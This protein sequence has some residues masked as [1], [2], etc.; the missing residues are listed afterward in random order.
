MKKPVAATGH[1]AR[2]NGKLPK[3]DASL[4][5]NEYLYGI[6]GTPAG[7]MRPADRLPLTEECKHHS[8]FD[9]MPESLQKYVASMIPCI[10]A[11][12]TSVLN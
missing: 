2:S 9:E 12:V 1:P 4:I 3:Q 5:N 10:T 6:Y 7:V 11:R 8:S